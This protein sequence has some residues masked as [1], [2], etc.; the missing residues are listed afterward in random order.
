MFLRSVVKQ[1]VEWFSIDKR[2]HQY[3]TAYTLKP[4][5]SF[6]QMY[7]GW[8]VGRDRKTN[9]PRAMC[10]RKDCGGGADRDPWRSLLE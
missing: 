7:F 6:Q 3:T 8:E 4:N 9:I 10:H 1:T 2:Q 5:E